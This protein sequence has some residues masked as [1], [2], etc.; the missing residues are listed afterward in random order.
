MMHIIKHNYGKVEVIS[1]KEKDSSCSTISDLCPAKH[2]TTEMK[3]STLF[4]L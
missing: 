3:W 1:A 2:Y 4:N